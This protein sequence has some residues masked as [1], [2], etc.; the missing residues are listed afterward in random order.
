MGKK[1]DYINTE[2]SDVG[3]KKLWCSS[4]GSVAWW[5]SKC[6]TAQSGGVHGQELALASTCT[7]DTNTHVGCFYKECFFHLFLLCLVFVVFK[8]VVLLGKKRNYLFN[9]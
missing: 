6:C 8:L 5:G 2:N 1:T 9:V 4:C 7:K 3:G